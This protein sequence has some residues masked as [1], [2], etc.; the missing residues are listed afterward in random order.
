VPWWIGE[1]GKSQ[2]CHVFSVEDTVRFPVR[3]RPILSGFP[4]EA[5]GAD[6]K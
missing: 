5:I 3:S 1:S 4:D 2:Y 6:L